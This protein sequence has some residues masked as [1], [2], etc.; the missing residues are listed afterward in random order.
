MVPT[1]DDHDASGGAIPANTRPIIITTPGVG[2]QQQHQQQQGR[3][4]A[5]GPV[6]CI[7]LSHQ[8]SKHIQKLLLYRRRLP[9]DAVFRPK[10]QG[11][12][13]VL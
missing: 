8:V 6:A 1:D 12:D 13:L 11:V 9:G 10:D 3:T 7:S 4:A 5:A 2:K